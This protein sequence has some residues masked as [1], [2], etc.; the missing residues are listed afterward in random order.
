MAVT[1]PLTVALVGDNVSGGNGIDILNGGAGGD[2]LSG[3]DGNDSLIG[4]A[5]D[6]LL[7][8]GAGNDTLTGGAGGDRFVLV[9]VNNGIDTIVDFM[10]G[11]DRIGLS[12]GLNF[13]QLNITQG[14]GG[15]VNDTLISLKSNDDLL[16][17]LTGVESTTLNGADF[18]IV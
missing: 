3:G 10:D 11:E 6:D 18:A 8:G 17:I 1:T 7:V 12:G 5:G 2:K 9:A 16:A 14:T 15:N 13:G 4:G